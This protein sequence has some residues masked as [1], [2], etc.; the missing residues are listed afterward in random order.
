M[1]FAN[2]GKKVF[3]KGTATVRSALNKGEEVADAAKYAAQE[4]F[5]IANDALRQF[6]LSPSV[7]LRLIELARENSDAT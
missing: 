5:V 4:S 6:N 7:N 3:E 1:S 2:E